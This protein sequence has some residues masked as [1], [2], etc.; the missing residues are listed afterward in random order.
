MILVLIDAHSKWIKASNCLAVQIEKR[1]L[2]ITQGSIRS[3]L[4]KTLFSY[5]L[6][7]QT[8]TGIVAIDLDVLS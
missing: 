8:T 4:A 2:K 1:G 5:R 3:R 6:T 7:P